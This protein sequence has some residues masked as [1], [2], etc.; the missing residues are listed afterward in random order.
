M[1]TVDSR[2][3]EAI[4]A[5]IGNTV[6]RMIELQ[7]EHERNRNERDLVIEQASQSESEPSEGQEKMDE[8]LRHLNEQASTSEPRREKKQKLPK[9]TEPVCEEKPDGHRDREEVL[10]AER[11]RQKIADGLRE[12][13]PTF[14]LQLD[15]ILELSTINACRVRSITLIRRLSGRDSCKPPS[16]SGNVT[17]KSLN[18]SNSSA[19]KIRE[20]HLV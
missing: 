17:L 12:V 3:Q 1:L 8:M 4:F 15:I 19:I 6:A 14:P 5:E 10:F 7:D 9:T 13:H 18:V 2:A 20:T 16:M 11:L